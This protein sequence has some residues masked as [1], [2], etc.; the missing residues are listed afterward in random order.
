MRTRTPPNTR[1]ALR[2][3]SCVKRRYHTR[4]GSPCSPHPT[5]SLI[6]GAPPP[7]PPQRVKEKSTKK[8]LKVLG[9]TKSNVVVPDARVVP[10]SERRAQVPRFVVPGAA[11]EHAPAASRPA[12]PLKDC[13]CKDRPAQTLR[14]RMLRMANPA[15]HAWIKSV[16]IH[17]ARGIRP[18]KPAQ[19]AGKTMAVVVAQSPPVREHQITQQIQT[20]RDRRDGDN[21]WPRIAR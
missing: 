14:V 10:E 15:L 6:Q 9:E 8:L 17:P 7:G 13:P 12:P 4:W 18:R 19:L 2:T 21:N 16:P 20:E 3:A 1:P 5:R 11:A